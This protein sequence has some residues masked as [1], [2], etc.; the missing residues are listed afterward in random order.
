MKDES[1]ILKQYWRPAMAWSYL[2][3]CL[4]DFLVA[5]IFF[6]W[7]AKHASITLEM[8]KPLT[9]VEGGMFHMAMGAILGVA[10]WTRGQEKIA[11][12]GNSSYGR[13][14]D[15]PVITSKESSY[16][17]TKAEKPD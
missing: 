1:S 3:I 4:W 13:V 6:A 16:I 17:S 11:L 7:W 10:A 12:I 9:L 2:T 15:D 14:Y 5:P 8:W